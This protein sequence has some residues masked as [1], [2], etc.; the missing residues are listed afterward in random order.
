[1][2]DDVVIVDAL[3]QLPSGKVDR[4]ALREWIVAGQGPLAKS[5]AT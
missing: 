3:P 5:T 2:P 1:V 4:R